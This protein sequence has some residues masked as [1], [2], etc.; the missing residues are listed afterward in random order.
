MLIEETDEEEEDFYFYVYNIWPSNSMGFFALFYPGFAY[1]YQPKSLIA[2]LM[3]QTLE[4]G[5]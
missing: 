3:A 1:S 4:G 2:F 5:A